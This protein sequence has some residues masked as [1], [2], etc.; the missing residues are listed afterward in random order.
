MQ[1]FHQGGGRGAGGPL[2]CFVRV[3]PLCPHEHCSDKTVSFQKW[4]LRLRPLLSSW[5]HVL[6]YEMKSVLDLHSGHR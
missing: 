2:V 1:S 6:L 4:G 3:P 5:D